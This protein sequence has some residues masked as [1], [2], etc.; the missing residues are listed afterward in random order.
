MSSIHAELPFTFRPARAHDAP[1]QE[2]HLRAVAQVQP[3]APA[4]LRL[5][6]RGRVAVVLAALM[7]IAALAV[8]FGSSTAATDA[9]GRIVETTMIT[10]QPGQ[11]MW[12]IAAAANPSG[13]VRDTIDDIVRLNSLPNASGL[14]MGTSLAVP[15]YGD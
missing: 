10:V 12:S 4:E 1:R 3:A 14:Q 5:T 13:D 11:T 9:S 2:R 6:R 15:V 8:T 7:V